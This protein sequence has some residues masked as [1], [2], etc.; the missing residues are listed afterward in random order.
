MLVPV[1]DKRLKNRNQ[2]DCRRLGLEHAWAEAK[3]ENIILIRKPFDLIRVE[4]TFRPDQQ[5]A[6]RRRGPG[7]TGVVTD[8]PARSRPRRPGGR[9]R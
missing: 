8:R 4:A 6:G 7:R 1:P 9:D 5:R 2:G 3:A